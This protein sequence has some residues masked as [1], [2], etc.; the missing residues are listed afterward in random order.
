[1]R[2][3]PLLVLCATPALAAEGEPVT[4]SVWGVGVIVIALAV[5]AFIG[6]RR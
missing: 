2:A 1:M 4:R 6:S 5:L 3:A